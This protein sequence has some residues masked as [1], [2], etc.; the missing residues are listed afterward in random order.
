M[1]RMGSPPAK[2][3]VLR[4]FVDRCRLRDVERLTLVHLSG[5]GGSG[6]TQL[7]TYEASEVIGSELEEETEAF[8][9]LIITRCHA[10][11]D[12]TRSTGSFKLF[13][14]RANEE[15]HVFC[16]SPMVFQVHQDALEDG[17]FEGSTNLAGI[18]KTLTSHI[19]RREYQSAQ[20]LELI[21]RM[22]LR[23]T[24]SANRRIE[25]YEAHGLK[26][27]ELEQQLLD[28]RQERELDAE[29]QK[30]TLEGQK[31][32][33][34]QLGP[35]VPTVI[36]HLA[37]SV[38]GGKIAPPKAV[39]ESDESDG[40]REA[41]V[42]ERFAMWIQKHEGATDKLAEI[43]GEDEAAALLEFAALDGGELRGA[44]LLWMSEHDITKKTIAEVAGE[45][46][47]AEFMAILKGE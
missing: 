27:F 33:I 30:A 1:G 18:V 11:T 29:K 42:R 2:E 45:A 36:Q 35:Y 13:A 6:G 26:V 15:R 32:I 23:G 31:A 39:D 28:R 38:T 22:A 7:D 44:I 16:T 37:S 34:K 12:G 5:N 17:N 47:Q 19:E 40:P 21:V 41:T 25:Q 20:Q 4:D 9:D 8:I 3:D 24:E 43:V 14:Y 10:E 46:G